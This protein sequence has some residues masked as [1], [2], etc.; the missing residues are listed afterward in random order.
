MFQLRETRIDTKQDLY[1]VMSDEAK[2]LIGDERNFIANSANIASL[3]FH[4]LQDLN[5]AG[6][7]IRH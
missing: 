7:Y 4:M 2:N 1:R 6:F 5:W 3:I